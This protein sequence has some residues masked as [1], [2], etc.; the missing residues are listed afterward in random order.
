MRLKIGEEIKPLMFDYRDCNRTD[1]GN[2]S[3]YYTQV[4]LLWL[5]AT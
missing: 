3:L 4:I 1:C 2:A 5:F